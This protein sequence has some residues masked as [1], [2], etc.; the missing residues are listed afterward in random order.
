M[1]PNINF[2][3]QIQS[4]TIPIIAVAQKLEALSETLDSSILK[5]YSI[6]LET[7]LNKLTT[8]YNEKIRN[9]K[10]IH[11]E[12]TNELKNSYE[13]KI[14]ILQNLKNRIVKR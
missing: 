8:L 12:K 2:L 13:E 11:N 9:I 1:N 3:D 7:E 5:N 14:N 6:I 4:H 10:V